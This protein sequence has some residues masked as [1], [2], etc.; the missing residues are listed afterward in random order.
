L[1]AALI[2]SISDAALAVAKE[3]GSPPETKETAAMW[4]FGE[5]SAAAVLIWSHPNILL[6]HFAA[7]ARIAHGAKAAARSVADA[8]TSELFVFPPRMRVLTVELQTRWSV[9]GTPR[10][11]LVPALLGLLV[12]VLL[13]APPSRKAVAAEA[14]AKRS[15]RSL[16]LF[17]FAER[18]SAWRSSRCSL[19]ITS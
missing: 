8:V 19:A 18:R 16:S 15:C 10:Q 6:S 5:A 3:V 1:D 11:A 7:G 12:L 14:L 4:S 2:S 13:Q 9:L 17:G